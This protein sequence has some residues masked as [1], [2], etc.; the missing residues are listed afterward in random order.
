M[1]VYKETQYELKWGTKWLTD[2]SRAMDPVGTCS[3]SWFL[4]SLSS[5]ANWSLIKSL[6]LCLFLFMTL[7]D[8]TDKEKDRTE[9]KQYK[10][11]SLD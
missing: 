11:G 8:T 3:D 9:Y 10:H 2:I 1:I 4:D 5:M 6:I 7:S